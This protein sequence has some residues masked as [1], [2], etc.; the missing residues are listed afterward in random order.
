MMTSPRQTTSP[1]PPAGTEARAIG[2]GGMEQRLLR[3]VLASL[4][5]H[6]EQIAPHREMLSSLQIADPLLGQLL[7]AMVRCS[8]RKETVETQ[9]LLTILG[10]GEVYNM[11]KGMLRADTFTLTP[12]RMTPDPDRVA[13][14]LEEAVRV[15]A[16]GP[17]LEAALVEATRRFESDFS[18]ANF[19][20][21]QRIRALKADHDRRLAELAQS[22]DSI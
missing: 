21:Q 20:E 5:R 15:M 6:P 7:A 16:Q 2:A 13:R 12:N 22:E 10:Q 11:A 1:I 19:A 4:L 9:A 14:D 3:A 8:L 17:E 18:E